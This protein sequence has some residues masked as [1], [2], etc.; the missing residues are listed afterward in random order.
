MSSTTLSVFFFLTRV[1]I[2]K[3]FSAINASIIE[4][5]DVPSVVHNGTGPIKLSCIYKID[6][7]ENGLVV[8]WYHELDQIYQWIPPATSRYGYNRKLLEISSG[9]FETTRDTI[10]NLFKNDYS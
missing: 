8:K 5:I 7:N 3:Y 1:I 4:R 10:D 6:K 2:L 9:E